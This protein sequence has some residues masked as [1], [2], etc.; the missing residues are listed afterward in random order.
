LYDC[1]FQLTFPSMLSKTNEKIKKAWAFYDWA[2]S[3]Y[4][5]VISTAIFPMFYEAVTGP[6]NNPSGTDH[7]SFWG[8][9]FVNTELYSYV[10]AASFLFVIVL[11]PPLSGIADA[12]GKKKFF[13]S[14]FCYIG[15]IACASLFFFDPEHLEWS[16]L[17][18][19][20]ASLGYW[21]SI[22]FYNAFLPEIAPPEEHDR[23][24]ARGFSMGYIGS[25]L[26][27]SINLV[28][29]LGIETETNL[30]PWC[31]V[32]VALWW[33][34]FA[35]VTLRKLPDNPYA[36]QIKGS[37]WRAGF[38]EV[39][40][41]F[42]QVIHLKRLSRYLLA[43]F[44]FSMA[45]QT[46][47]LM[48]QF[49]GMKEIHQVIDGVE[50]TGLTSAQFIIAI[51]LIQVIAIPGAFLFSRTSEKFGNLF[52]LKL[53]LVLWIG[54]CVY[55]YA[56]VDTPMEFYIA[57]AWIGFIMGGT[58]SLGRSTYSKFLPETQD[59]A[60]FFSFYDILEKA[61]IVIGMISFGAIEGMSDNMRTPILALVAFFGAGL[62]LLY[63]VPKSESGQKERLT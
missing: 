27:L 58:Q 11:S 38:S 43:F 15:S 23:L 53:A 26:L 63:F 40:K 57:A 55:A 22:V 36:K 48:A 61:G 20:I 35:Q 59:H 8:M 31:F 28:M 29:I 2:N 45:V 42:H 44:V 24:S 49:F 21:G 9:D 10:I 47:M 25:V 19:M 12:G 37:A 39:K 3:V 33:A 51:L 14:L 1:L 50:K 16:M 56:L 52:T 18:V 5:L 60:S 4:P 62:L 7:V 13:L 32:M 17:P 41:V 6:E 46:I 30:V 54:V 34:G